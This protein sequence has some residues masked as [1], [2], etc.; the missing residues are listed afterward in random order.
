MS[1]Y[2]EEYAWACACVDGNPRPFIHSSSIRPRRSDAQAYVA[3]AWRRD[4]ETLRQSWKRAYRN[5][6]RCI[7]VVVSPA[8]EVLK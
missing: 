8:F 1:L 5:G 7:R 3:G 4:G 6:W 2:R